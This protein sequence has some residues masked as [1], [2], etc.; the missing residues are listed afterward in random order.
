MYRLK[1]THL[2]KQSKHSLTHAHAQSHLETTRHQDWSGSIAGST[3][4]PPPSAVAAV[5][6]SL[7]LRIN[8]ASPEVK[9][10][11]SSLLPKSEFI[12]SRTRH[13]PL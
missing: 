13:A 4:L 8:R 6:P 10:L 2:D 11:L 5:P 1:F 3:Q 12:L 9:P 7:P